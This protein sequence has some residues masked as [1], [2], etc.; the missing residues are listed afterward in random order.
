MTIGQ[1]IFNPFFSGTKPLSMDSSPG[2]CAAPY[3]TTTTMSRLLACSMS[4]DRSQQRLF[5]LRELDRKLCEDRKSPFDHLMPRSVVK[6]TMRIVVT[7]GSLVLSNYANDQLQQD[8][9]RDKLV[10]QGEM[11]PAEAEDAS[12]EWE[13]RE[14]KVRWEALPAKLTETLVKYHVIV[15]VVRLYEEIASRIVDNFTMDALT[16]DTFKVSRRLTAKEDDRSELGKQMFQ[17][18]GQANLISFMADYSVHQA[19]LGWGYYTYTRDRKRRRQSRLEN[20]VTGKKNVDDDAAA[21]DDDDN[22]E[23][24]IVK[25]SASLALSRGLGLAFTA[26]GGGV[27]SMLLPGWGTLLGSNFGDTLGGAVS[28][29]VVALSSFATE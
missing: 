13:Q 1:R 10:D 23:F 17:I 3:A 7:Q 6:S 12:E 27:G 25:K 22:K 14:W 8:M 20:Q 4:I 29:G 2:S 18:C 28:D 19:I 11:T 16:L 24:P 21:V 5:A 26:V 15:L 9:A